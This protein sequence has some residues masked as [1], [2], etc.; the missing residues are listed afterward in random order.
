[1]DAVQRDV[2]PVYLQ[3]AISMT[4]SCHCRVI[5]FEDLNGRCLNC[6]TWRKEGKRRDMAEN[7]TLLK[8]RE[9]GSKEGREGRRKE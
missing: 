8:T 9:K 5:S 6:R 2:S 3:G 1:M 4:V 7:K